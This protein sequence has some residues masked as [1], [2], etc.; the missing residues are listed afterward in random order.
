MN[1]GHPE[2]G[3]VLLLA[4]DLI[5]AAAATIFATRIDPVNHSSFAQRM[6]EIAMFMLIFSTCFYVFD[7]YDV[8]ALNGART[9][10]RLLAAAVLGICILSFF[11]LF[12]QWTGFSRVSMAISV[13]MLLVGSFSW[14]RFYRRNRSL[15]LKRRGVLLVGTVEEAIALRSVT[16]SD[17]SQYKLIGLLRIHGATVAASAGAISKTLAPLPDVAFSSRAQQRVGITA[18]EEMDGARIPSEDTAGQQTVEDCGLVSPALLE[19]VV[20]NRGVD[21]IVVRPESA[22]TELAEALT[23]LRFRGIRISTMPDLCS[24]ILEKLPLDTLSGAWFSFATGFNL[25]HA[26]IFRKVKRLTD[27]LLACA[28]LLITLPISLGVAI[29]IKLESPGPVLFRQWRVGWREKPFLL[30]KFRS[31]RQDAESDGKPQ[32]ASATDPRVT[33]VGAI[34]RRLHID[35]IPQM[36]NVLLGEMSFIGPRPERPAFVEQLNTLVPFYHLRHYLPPGITGWAQVNYPYG[37]CVEDARKK[38]QYD[39]F[40]VRNASPTLDLRILLRTA[41]VV[42]FRSGSR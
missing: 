23:R 32:W 34:L 42:L 31:M 30:L 12:F 21:T 40:Y 24:Q 17:H 6:G 4:G 36:I 22:V 7:L 11:L 38:L 19:E 2:R 35:E 33:R 20:L 10:T 1:W 9:I 27:I 13:P 41:R 39:L 14:R 25:L 3:K 16:E 18:V 8:R 29:A 28:G 37:D 5:L 15:L 26:R